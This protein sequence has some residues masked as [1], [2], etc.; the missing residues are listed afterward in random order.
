MRFPPLLSP[1]VLL[2]S[3][4]FNGRGPAAGV[5]KEM[6]AAVRGIFEN[7]CYDCHADGAKKGGVALDA[8]KSHDDLLA[9][10]ELWLRVLKNVR[11]G[12]MPPPEKDQPSA[13]ERARIQQWITDSIFAFEPAQPDPGR[14]VLRRLNRVEYRNTIEDLTGVNFRVQDEFP[15]DDSGHGFDNLGEVLTLSPMLLEKYLAAAQSITAEAL[16]KHRDRILPGA[17]PAEP[18]PRRVY[19][20]EQLSKFAARA[21]RRPVEPE[22]VD[23]LL[24]MAEATWAQPGKSFEDGISRALEGIL[25]SPRFLFREEFTAPLDAGQKHPLVDEYSLASR[26]SYFLWS[27]LPDAELL[28]LAGEGKLRAELGAQF[29][30]MLKDERSRAFVRNFSGQWLQSRDI[31]SIPI[32]AR[33]VLMREQKPDPEADAA[34]KRMFELRRKREEERTPEEQEELRKARD[35]FRRT[36]S[37]FEGAEFR[38]DV[39][40]DMRRET[41]MYFTHVLKEGRPLT[42]LIASDYTF[43]NQRLAKHYG[44]PGVEGDE[45]RRVTLPADSPRGGM[46]TQGSVLA[47]TS[48]PTRTSPVKRGLFILDNILGTPPPPPPPD[49]PPLEDNGRGRGFEGTLRQNLERHRAD[50]KCAGCHNRMDP[51]GLAFENFNAMGQWREFERGQ[52]VDPTGRLVSG[53]SFTGAREL[54]QILVAK[55]KDAFHRCF[56][57][58]LLTYALGRGLDW[59]DEQT[60]DALLEKLHQNEG[61]LLPLLRAVVESPAFQRRSLR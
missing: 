29:D 55:H 10:K 47:V 17:V 12:L 52:N 38:R 15:T 9:D 8:F 2:A 20:R 32:D 33:F 56:T 16:A 43:L 25:A 27:T 4:L 22:T 5:E 35:T 31:E 3:L 41:E 39:R 50:A 51:L 18:E 1:L 14:P 54:K 59:R 7:R 57:E 30:R 6:P 49:V 58:K 42:E 23:R 60:I 45:I 28:R 48:N 44:V 61:R 40:Q 37:R 34:R 24:K 11:A 26:L 21:F 36:F 46:L 19:V 53:E 13:E